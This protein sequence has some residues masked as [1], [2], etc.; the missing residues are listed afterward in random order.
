M[1]KFIILFCRGSPEP[2]GYGH[3]KQETGGQIDEQ[4]AIALGMVPTEVAQLRTL[5]VR[6]SVLFRKTTHKST[7]VL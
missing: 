1:L 2:I 7:A 4:T 3:G 6:V 5:C